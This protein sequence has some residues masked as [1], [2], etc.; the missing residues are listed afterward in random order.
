MLIL[1]VAATLIGSFIVEMLVRRFKD[2]Y[3]L[4]WPAAAVVPENAMALEIAATLRRAAVNL[5]GK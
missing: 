4:E 3:E 2:S 5:N 1:L